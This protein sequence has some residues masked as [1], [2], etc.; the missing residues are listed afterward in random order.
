MTNHM[1]KKEIF[2]TILKSIVEPDADC[3]PH[4]IVCISST[5]DNK[6]KYTP[7]YRQPISDNTFL[8]TVCG[9][10]ISVNVE[11]QIALNVTPCGWDNG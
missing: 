10:N 8:G 1:I 11:V 7:P 3:S 5:K 6:W 2:W 9:P 4:I